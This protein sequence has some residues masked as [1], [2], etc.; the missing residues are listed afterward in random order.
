MNPVTEKLYRHLE[1]IQNKKDQTLYKKSNGSFEAVSDPWVIEGL[2]SGWWL[3]QVRPGSTSIRCCINPDK[4]PIQA[5]AI[6]MEDKLIDIIRK[7]SEAKPA[8]IPL[9]ESL[10]KDWDRLIAKHGNELSS[11]QFPS[12]QQNAQ[13]II[14]A[15]IHE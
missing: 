11:L 12:F 10:R 15:I 6:N 5:A 3:V 2:T 7:A 8:K 14:K 4:A 13:D 1:Q 9:S